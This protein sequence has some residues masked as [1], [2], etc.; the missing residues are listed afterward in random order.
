MKIKEYPVFFYVFPMIFL[1]VSL[2]FLGLSRLFL[3]C[4]RCFLG[5]S[6]EI[7]SYMSLL[8]AF[9]GAGMTERLLHKFSNG[10]YKFR[11]LSINV[12]VC[13]S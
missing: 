13:L 8:G 3:G 12:H 5:F 4:P 7:P 11:L 9:A 1:G 10:F 6:P 2:F